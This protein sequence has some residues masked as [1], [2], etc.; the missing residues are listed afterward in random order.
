MP[1]PY[2]EEFMRF[3]TTTDST[4]LGVTLGKACVKANLPLVHV[5]RGLSISKVTLFNWFRGRGMRENMRDKVEPFLE[6]IQRDLE[7][8]VLPASSTNEAVIYIREV[9][10][11]RVENTEIAQ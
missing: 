8:G 1:R 11:P 7:S 3:I 9:T 5:A 10:S 4:S 2:S 6:T